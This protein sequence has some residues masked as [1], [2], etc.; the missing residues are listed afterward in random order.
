MEKIYDKA[1]IAAMS[2]E[3]YE[4]YWSEIFAEEKRLD[5]KATIYNEGKA[6]GKT[7]DAIKMLELG[8]DTNVISQVTGFSPDY[9]LSLKEKTAEEQGAKD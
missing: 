5:E 2:R 3:E 6:E 8:F 9:I 4:A 1:R 7:E